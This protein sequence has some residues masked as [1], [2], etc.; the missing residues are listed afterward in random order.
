MRD[1]SR[2]D[3]TLEMVGKIWKQVP[4]WRFMQMICNLQRFMGSDGF[5]LEEERF[6]TKLNEFVTYI[7]DE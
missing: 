4:D 1:E 3:K 5:Y 2:I 6:V 7:K